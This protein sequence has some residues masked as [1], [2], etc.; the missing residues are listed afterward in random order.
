MTEEELIGIARG[1]MRELPRV[2]GEGWATEAV[3][4]K[5]IVQET[6]IVRFEGKDAER[7][8]MILL[9]RESGKFIGS[10]L[11]P[12]PKSDCES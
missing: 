9:D 10:W 7:K 2:S 5:V 1:H 6:V 8:V 4:N 3:L 12:S 11:T